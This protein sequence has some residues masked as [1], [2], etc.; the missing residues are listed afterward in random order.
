VTIAYANSDGVP[1]AQAV[2]AVEKL[3]SVGRADVT[4][5]D[6]V[7]VLLER[8]ERSYTW[9]EISRISLAG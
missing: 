2:A 5:K 7:M 8:R 9:Q 1:A 4:I 6:G 3:S